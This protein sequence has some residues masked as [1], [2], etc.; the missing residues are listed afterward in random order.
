MAGFLDVWEAL[1]CVTNALLVYLVQGCSAP[2][3]G[4]ASPHPCVVGHTG[5]LSLLWNS[6]YNICCAS[7]SHASSAPWDQ[8]TGVCQGTKSKC[9][10]GLI[11]T[12]PVLSKTCWFFSLWIN[13]TTGQAVPICGNPCITSQVLRAWT[14]GLCKGSSQTRT[15][16][17]CIQFF[18]WMCNYCWEVSLPVLGLELHLELFFHWFN[19]FWVF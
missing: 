8:I 19:T 4:V 17:S 2:W 15:K 9:W 18:W 16:I 14:P 11:H 12:T 10:V 5:N 7:S 3:R 1:V 6:V 13:L